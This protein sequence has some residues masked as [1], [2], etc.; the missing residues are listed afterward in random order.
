MFSVFTGKVFLVK[1]MGRFCVSST[2]LYP[3]P[4]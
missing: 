3:P 1:V 4:V 2:G